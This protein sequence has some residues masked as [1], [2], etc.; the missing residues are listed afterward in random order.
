MKKRPQLS[1]DM[2]P[3]SPSSPSSWQWGQTTYRKENMSIGYNYLR[4]EGRTVS[5]G[6][7]D[8]ERLDLEEVLGKGHFST[9]RR[10][11]W[12]KD[13]ENELQ[14]AVKQLSLTQSSK[15]RHAMILQELRTLCM[16]QSDFLVSLHGAF[17]LEDT[18]YMVLEIMD[19]GSLLDCIQ[20]N[21]CKPFS[22]SFVASIAFQVLKGLEHL[23]TNQMIHRD[24]KPANILVNSS[25]NI[26]LCDFGMATLNENS[27]HCTVVGT[28]KYMAP[29][30]LRGLPYG[31]SSDVWS[32]G[33]VL[34]QCVTGKEPWSDVHSMVDL[35]I[36][37]EESTLEELVP[38]C[39]KSGLE[40]IIV[41]SLQKSPGAFSTM[42]DLL[43]F[44]SRMILKICGSHKF[45]SLLD[46]IFYI[47]F[48]GF[49]GLKLNEFL[50]MYC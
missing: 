43:L 16:F 19:R 2:M 30:R 13:Q 5:R 11:T 14:V 1:L 40:E 17:L 8:P 42:A 32:F 50:Q 9:V 33:L 41:F 7:L 3:S 6:Q 21:D 10:A 28:T 22:D 36:T 44:R 48:C 27:M 24:I 31:R 26:K 4:V 20:R 25:G 35:V 18:I 39:L 45:I 46:F 12:R 29:E 15:K 34:L 38:P 49:C 23:H 37:V 47:F